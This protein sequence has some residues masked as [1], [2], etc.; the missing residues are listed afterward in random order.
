VGQSA[1]HEHALKRRK[2]AIGSAEDGDLVIKDSTV[3]QRHA[4]IRR[5]FFRRHKVI[6]LDSTN[7]TFLNTKRITRPTRI[8]KGDELRF[9]AARFVFLEAPARPGKECGA[10]P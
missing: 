10:L 4:V 1:P 8:A 6:D 5:S 2:V 7:G 9:G 3:S